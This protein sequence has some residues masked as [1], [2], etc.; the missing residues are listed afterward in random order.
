VNG[1]EGVGVGG[2]AELIEDGD[3]LVVR[4]VGSGDERIG[5]A[6]LMED[7]EGRRVG[8]GGKAAACGVAAV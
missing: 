3:D 2:I 8:R 6:I 5:V 7:F 4:S 1:V